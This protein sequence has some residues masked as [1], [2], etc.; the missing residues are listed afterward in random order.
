LFKGKK[1]DSASLD[2]SFIESRAAPDSFFGASGGQHVNTRDGA[3]ANASRSGSSSMVYSPSQLD[4]AGDVDPVAEADVYLAY[5]RDMQ[6]EEILKEAQRTHPGRISIHRKL[7]EIYAKR[8]DPRALEAVAVEAYD[9]THGQ[10]A[11]WLAIAALGAELDQAN[12]LY[13]PGGSPSARTAQMPV[14]PV[15]GADTEPATAM[16]PPASSAPKTAPAAIAPTIPAPMYAA[17]AASA[18]AA[19]ASREGPV[20]QP[21]DLDLGSLDFSPPPQP[22][23]APAVPAPRV[24]APAPLTATAPKPVAPKPASPPAKPAASGNSGMMDFDMKAL[25]ANPDERSSDAPI[26]HQPDDAD[27]DPL[28]TK[29]ALAQEFH[30]IGDNEGARSLVKEVLAQATGSLKTRAER[31]LSELN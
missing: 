4:A 18:A 28:A 21:V 30:A 20:S 29:L 10:G 8:R 22:K 2:S 5:G 16:M 14:R 23:A 26:T 6:A 13:K 9:I 19:A 27:D 25:S 15:F 31:F 11:D 1:K 24:S 7:A 3:S 17:T 12:P